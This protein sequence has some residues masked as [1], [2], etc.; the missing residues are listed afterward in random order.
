[1]KNMSKYLKNTNAIARAVLEDTSATRKQNE[2]LLSLLTEQRQE[3]RKMCSYIEAQIPDIN[4]YFP[5]KDDEALNRF[6]DESDGRYPLRRSEFY[7][8]LMSCLND[9][10][11]LMRTSMLKTFFSQ[12]YINTHVWPSYA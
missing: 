12:K 1:M 7:N 2:V 6:F 9:K 3:N 10:E 4:H 11:N 5:V 8:L